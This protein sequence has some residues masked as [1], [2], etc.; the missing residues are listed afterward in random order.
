MSV[1]RPLISSVGRHSGQ[2]YTFL[3]AYLRIDGSIDVVTPKGKINL[4]RTFQH[5]RECR[6]WLH[7]KE[8]T[9]TG[10]IVTDEERD[11]LLAR[12]VETH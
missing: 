10:E 5:A 11:S 9:V 7:G 6:V 4:C 3:V 8:Y 1:R 12:Y 2:R